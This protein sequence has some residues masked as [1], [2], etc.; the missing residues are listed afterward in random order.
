MPMNSTIPHSKAG[1]C[2][3]W[4]SV[5]Y[6]FLIPAPRPVSHTETNKNFN[7]RRDRHLPGLIWKRV[8]GHCIYCDLSSEETLGSLVRQRRRFVRL[9]SLGLSGIILYEIPAAT[10]PRTDEPP[11]RMTLRSVF[12]DPTD[13]SE[14]GM[15]IND[16]LD[17]VN[18]R[19]IYFPS[20]C[21]SFTVS[22]LCIYG[23][24]SALMSTSV[25]DWSSHVRFPLTTASYSTIAC[26]GRILC[27]RYCLHQF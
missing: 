23:V 6:S 20:Y 26:S 2:S 18:A 21:T 4:S 12:G 5:L 15:D 13:P 27:R 25:V 8:L 24:I 10:T 17:D 19:V 3:W 9:E 7:P 14:H 1:P 11:T 16:L 22:T